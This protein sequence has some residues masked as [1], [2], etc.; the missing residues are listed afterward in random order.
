MKSASAVKIRPKLINGKVWV[1][2]QSFLDSYEPLSED[3]PHYQEVCLKS[4]GRVWKTNGNIDHHHLGLKLLYAI[5]LRWDLEAS[6]LK[7]LTGQ[8]DFAL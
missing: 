5:D 6:A 4:T 1:P 7:R 8:A 3:D 2:C